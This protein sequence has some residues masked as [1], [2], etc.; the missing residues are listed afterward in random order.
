MNTI[1][2][3]SAN[4]CKPCTQLQKQIDELVIDTEIFT[5]EYYDIEEWPDLAKEYNIRSIPTL[6]KLDESLTEVSRKIGSLTN[7][8]L[9]EFVNEQK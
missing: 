5:I 9:L 1:L 6:I 4:W 8:Q 7:E 3:F 2:K